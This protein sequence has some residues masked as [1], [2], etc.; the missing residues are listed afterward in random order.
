MVK[1]N[2]AYK[3]ETGLL[4]SYQFLLCYRRSTKTRPAID[5][6]QSMMFRLHNNTIQQIH[7][8]VLLLACVAVLMSKMSQQSFRDDLVQKHAVYGRAQR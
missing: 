6:D 8:K 4:C 7:I 3:H 5:Y 1:E 2:K